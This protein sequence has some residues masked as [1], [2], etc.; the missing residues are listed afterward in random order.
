MNTVGFD[1]E[2]YYDTRLS[3]AKMPIV[4]YVLDPEFEVHLLSIYP[5]ASLKDELP[6]QVL[7]PEQIPAFLE[8]WAQRDDILW[9]AHNAVYDL[10]VWRYHYRLP[11]PKFYTDTLSLSRSLWGHR[12]KK[13]S[14]E[15]L[16]AFLFP[17]D[18]SLRK[19]KKILNIVKGR[20][21]VDI[22]PEVRTPYKAYAQQDTALLLPILQKIKEAGGLT[23]ERL[24][25][26]QRTLDMYLR[27]GLV[28]LPPLLKE[29][30]KTE[31]GRKLEALA[32]AKVTAAEVRS[33]TRF[34]QL[35]ASALGPG[36]AL[37][38]KISK[39]TKETTYAFSK[40][41]GAFVRL[42][43]DENPQ[44]RNLVAAK[45]ELGS[46]IVQKRAERLLQIA[47]VSPAWP[48]LLK[49]DAAHTYRYGGGDFVN[50]QN[51]PPE[52]K[53]AIVAPPGYLIFG[54]DLR[55]IEARVFAWLTDQRNLLQ[56]FRDG[57]DVYSWF[58]DRMDERAAQAGIIDQ[59]EAIYQQYNRRTLGKVGIL[60]LIYGAKENTIL[61][62]IG[63]PTANPYGPLKLIAARI[64]SLWFFLN[65]QANTLHAATLLIKNII[66]TPSARAR[67]QRREMDSQNG[68]TLRLPSGGN[69]RL[70]MD[71]E[72]YEWRLQYE[73]VEPLR[74]AMSTA[75][76]GYSPYLVCENLCQQLAFAVM[77]HFIV[78]TPRRFRLVL[79]EHDA[80]YY[81]VRE[82]EADA[83]RA[84]IERLPQHL[85]PWADGLPVD[86]EIKVGRTLAQ[87]R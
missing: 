54:Y 51:N 36:G 9:V 80:N 1:V 60:S 41:D 48:V 2:T 21:W 55:Q 16:A 86:L 63:G 71:A 6:A 46:S 45:L 47:A 85:P 61:Q 15:N 23:P 64:R 37:P 30:I 84:F 22:P 65:D 75:S 82:E 81:V 33:R 62:M 49:M 29:A 58:M 53:P 73:D 79:N 42:L 17:N 19:D 76:L 43:E 69:L 77:K 87:V 70:Q 38:K 5:S 8:R 74:Y 35:L 10:A 25:F 83:C 18:E 44:V 50:P 7:E 66:E 3:L 4:Q 28:L 24:V 31:R 67:W 20:H 72:R 13:L 12:L 57:V 14:L 40:S 68:Q 11:L 56:L 32:R 59:L 39:S 27:P 26:C 34:A 78:I 52:I